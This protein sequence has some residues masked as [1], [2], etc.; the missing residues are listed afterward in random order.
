MTAHSFNQTKAES[1]AE[2]MLGVLNDG[3]L[4]LMIS[5]GHRTGLFK[6]MAELPPSTS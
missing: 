3:S 2:N 1:F 6:A 5:L 4:A